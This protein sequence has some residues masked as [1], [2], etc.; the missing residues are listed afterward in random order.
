VDYP[1]L[2]HGF[3]LQLQAFDFDR[4]DNL[5]PHLRFAGRWQLS[6]NLYV[7]GGYDDPLENHSLFFGGGIRW[8]DDNIKYLLGSIPKF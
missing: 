6:P 7:I 4:P 5:Q 1:L 8:T 2:D 3:Q